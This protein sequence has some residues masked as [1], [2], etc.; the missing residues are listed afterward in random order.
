MM[1]TKKLKGAIKK[2]FTTYSR[3]CKL[4]DIDRYDFQKSLLSKD[5][6]TL[7]LHT[8]IESLMINTEDSTLISEKKLVKMRAAIDKAGGVKKFCENGKFAENT[9]FQILSGKGDYTRVTPTTT[10]LIKE[11]KIK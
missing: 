9:V 6:V 4:A 11:L 5:T 7:A 1:K 8:Q 3:F 10:A 2:K